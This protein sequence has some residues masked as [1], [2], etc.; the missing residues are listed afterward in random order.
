MVE[1]FERMQRLALEGDVF[2]YMWESGLDEAKRTSERSNVDL[3]YPPCLI[4]LH[5]YNDLIVPKLSLF[6]VLRIP[7]LNFYHRF[8]SILGVDVSC[9]RRKIP[10]HC[11]TNPENI[12]VMRH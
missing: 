5:F 11:C 10:L 3:L 1:N 8:G 4:L 6:P 9:T 12:P 2:V 7:V